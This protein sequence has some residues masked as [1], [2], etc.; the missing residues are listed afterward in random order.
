MNCI[1]RVPECCAPLF[2]A[3]LLT[4]CGGSA[5]H[6]GELPAGFD[7]MDDAGRVAWMMK[8]VP[9]DSVARFIC[10]GA[11]GQVPGG[12]IDTLATATLYA[13]ENYKDTALIAFA[14]AYDRCVDGMSLPDRMRLYV[15]AGTEDPQG[16]GYQLGLEYAGHIRQHKMTVE[17]V[18]REVAELR[19]ACGN[20]SATYQRFVK[21]FQTVLK[22]DR[23]KD[24]PEDIFNKFAN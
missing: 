19:R 16:L 3:A 21:G 6:H 2:M 12:R 9:A 5:S 15:M 4:G 7:A 1:R 24:L 18:E 20:D 11:L 22:I 8:H 10:R 17:Q 23:G 14:E 13:Y